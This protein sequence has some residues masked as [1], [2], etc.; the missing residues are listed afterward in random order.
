MFSIVAIALNLKRPTNIYNTLAISMFVILLIKP[1]FLFDVG[2]QLSYLAVFSIVAI[3]PF[4]FRLWQPKNKIISFYWHTLTITIAAQFGIIPVSLFYFHQFPGLF[5]ISNLIIIPFLGVILGFG[6]LVILLAVL[7]SLP[8]NIADA[9]GW[10]ISLMNKFVNW[11]SKQDA[12]LFKDIAFSLLYV[13]VSYVLITTFF[14]LIFK[15]SYSNL[16]L[17]LIAILVAQVA[18][19]YQ[20]FNKPSNEFIVF[21]KSRF[22]LLGKTLNN[23]INPLNLSM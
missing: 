21:H 17:F 3:D 8:Q 10:V 18:F 13:I 4:L 11:V 15:R 7:N 6:I 16:K 23:K 1:L 19:I 14:K 9:F 20:A 2:F 12:F 5:F 22:S